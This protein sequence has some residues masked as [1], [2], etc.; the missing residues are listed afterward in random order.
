VDHWVRFPEGARSELVLARVSRHSESKMF[1]IGFYDLDLYLGINLRY[2]AHLLGPLGYENGIQRRRTSLSL[3][4][5][6]EDAFLEVDTHI[7]RF[8][9]SKKSLVCKWIS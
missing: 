5:K 6:R 3:K 4:Q 2:A 8:K 9:S 1:R 7:F